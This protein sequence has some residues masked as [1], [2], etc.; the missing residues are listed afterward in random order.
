V[1]LL[2]VLFAS[3]LPA[4]VA[5][6]HPSRYSAHSMVNTCCTPYA[7]KA[8]L[9]AEAKD[10]GAA[11][12]RLDVVL[13][14]IFDVWNAPATERNWAGVDEVAALSRRYRLPVLAVMRATP[15]RISACPERRPDG[16]HR[17]APRDPRQFGRYVRAVIER[18]P[19]VFRA[20]EVWNEPDGA[21]AFDGTPAQYA[22]ML[23]ATYRAVKRRFRNVP[24]LIGGAMDL[25]GRHWYR[26]ALDAIRRGPAFDIAN[27]HVRGRVATV[28]ATVRRWLRFFRRH[29]HLGPLWV[30]EAGYPSDQQF[31][32]DPAYLG[33][34]RGQARYLRDALPA[35]VR[36]GAEQVFVTLRDSWS[37]EFGP[38]TPFGS[39]GVLT[40]DEHE[41]YSVR[42]KPAFGVIRRL[43]CR[44]RN[45]RVT[46]RLSVAGEVR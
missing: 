44:S 30:T 7:Q 17:C 19:D 43:A 25:D 26:R 2:A 18:A 15:A 20:I 16:H 40:M 8:R 34:E 13:D 31:Q 41:P 45:A 11:Y 14:S 37:T 32:S 10:M 39:E 28:G 12:I 22:E 24:V 27:V 23:S 36:A 3:L 6:A 4:A 9:F 33:G 38:A 1:L 46:P 29:G 42:R 5:S 21:W 35:M